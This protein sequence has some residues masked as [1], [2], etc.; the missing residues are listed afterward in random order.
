M[1]QQ[2]SLRGA[3]DLSSLAAPAAPA[4]SFVTE[5]DDASFDAA[6]Q[7]SV[8]YPVLIE[9]YSPRAPEAQRLSNDLAALTDEAGG[10]WL[11]VRVNVDAN[12]QLAAELQIKAVPTVAGVVSG[13]LVP[14]WQGTLGKEDAKARIEELLRL[15]AKYGVVGKAQ[16]VSAATGEAGAEPTMDPRYAAA[17]DAMEREDYVTARQ[18]FE[19]LLSASPSDAVAKAGL[20]QA[21]LLGRVAQSDPRSAVDRLAANPDDLDAV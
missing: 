6:V 12:A 17:Y 19:T 8:R 5:V 14:L 7:G 1:T 13:Q 20:A 4:G 18:E 3:I 11:L 9:F 2:H 16:P 15:A 21:G 10:R